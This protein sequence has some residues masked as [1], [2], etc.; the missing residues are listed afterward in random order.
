MKVSVCV[1]VY[2]VP[3]RYLRE[4]IDSALGQEGS[5]TL[6]VV[7]SDDASSADY[8]SLKQEYGS[9]PVTFYRNERNLGMAG[10]WNAAVNRSSGDLVLVLGHDDVLVEGMFAAYVA[11][12]AAYSDVVLC[13]SGRVFIDER[14]HE[15]QLRRAVNDRANIFIDLELYLLDSCEAIRL[16]L[17]NGN[18]IGEPSAVMFRRSVFNA[19]GGYDPGYKHAA[20]VHF[21]LRAA[22]NGRIAYFR[23]RFLRRRIHPENLTRSNLATGALTIDR[24]RMFEEFAD[25]C[26]FEPRTLAAFRAY[27]VACSTHDAVR[28]VRSGRWRTAAL[29]CRKALLYMRPTPRVYFRYL[30]EILNGNNADVR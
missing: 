19:I 24:A 26:D 12:F 3:I 14:G 17:R 9:D 5:F 2:D 13:G 6:E 16:C 23:E 10:N 25:E 22:R 7:V 1:P 4:A 29:G 28:G 21:N 20:D 18:V 15:V 27:L 11:A 8:S 30:S